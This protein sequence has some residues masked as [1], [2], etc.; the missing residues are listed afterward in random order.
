VSFLS[1]SLECKIIDDNVWVS[2][3]TWLLKFDIIWN[4]V[5]TGTF[6]SKIVLV[7]GVY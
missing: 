6:A 3:L 2:V 7:C 1:L 5:Y 4:K